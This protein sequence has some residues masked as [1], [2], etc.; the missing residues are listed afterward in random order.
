M[1]FAVS[2]VHSDKLHESYEVFE[3]LLD[4]GN[5]DIHAAIYVG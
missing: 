5:N 1:V 3:K 2:Y 4:T